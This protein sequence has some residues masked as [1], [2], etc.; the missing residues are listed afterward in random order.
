MIGV[1]EMALV[2][3]GK[4]AGFCGEIVGYS[5]GCYFLQFRAIGKMAI[6]PHQNARLANMIVGQTIEVTK[7]KHSGI[8]GPI[9]WLC[10]R[11]LGLLMTQSELVIPIKHTN[12]LEIAQALGLN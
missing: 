6:I 7:G 3:Q 9:W 4:M 1:G 2:V 10:E 12:L 11:D 8:F 5:S